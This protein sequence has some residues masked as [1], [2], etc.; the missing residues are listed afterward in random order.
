MYNDKFIYFYNLILQRKCLI[1]VVPHIRLCRKNV[2]ND[3]NIYE[4]C[5]EHF[6]IESVVIK[7]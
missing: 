1:V 2:M 4:I 7:G 5:S 3:L 6:K